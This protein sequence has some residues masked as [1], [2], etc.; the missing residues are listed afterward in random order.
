MSRSIRLKRQA[1]ADLNSHIIFLADETDIETAVRF[2]TATLDSFEFL[3]KTPLVGVERSYSNSRL[4]GLRMWFVRGFERYLI[5]YMVSE[6]EVLIV[7]VLHSSRDISG[8]FS[9]EISTEIED[10]DL[11]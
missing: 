7:R 2:D 4:R 10:N 11:S 6:K 3:A 5:F 8:I 9:D 1:E